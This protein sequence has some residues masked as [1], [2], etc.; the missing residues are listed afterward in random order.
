MR[1]FGKQE[2][3]LPENHDPRY[4]WLWR[5]DG[6]RILKEALSMYG[7][8][9]IKG[10]ENNPLI[11]EWAKEIGGWIGGWY[12]EDS[13]PW[14]GLFTGVCALRADFSFSQ[15][16]LSAKA[17]A[18]W[19]NPVDR[20]MLGDVLVFTRRGGG[21]VGL[22]V[23]EDKTTYH[24]LGGNQSDAVNITRLSKARLMTARRCP[25]RVAQ[26]DNVRVVHLT[27]GGKLSENE[28]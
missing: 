6:P 12:K 2:K 28:S 7:V 25:W 24:V 23:G 16:M 17:W 21:H 22:Y 27:V 13:V 4:A 8:L 26:P 5:E 3:P 11:I 14:C 10:E 20:P 15:K 18:E 19:G 1:I 9:E